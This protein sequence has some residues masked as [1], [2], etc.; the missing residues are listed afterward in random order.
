[1]NSSEL[2][3]AFKFFDTE[4]KGAISAADLKEKLGLF[5]QT[6]SAKDYKLLLQNKVPIMTIVSIRIIG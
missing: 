1:M 5:N 4:G 2:K 6:L 3:E